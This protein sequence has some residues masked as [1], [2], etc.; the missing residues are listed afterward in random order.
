[1][2]IFFL[3]IRRPPR[4]TLFPYTTLFRSEAAL[5]D[6][7]RVVG[8]EECNVAHPAVGGTTLDRKSTRLNSSHSSIS[9]AVFCLKKKRIWRE[10]LSRKLG[11]LQI[12]VDSLRT[13]VGRQLPQ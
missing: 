4:S 5:P 11:R 9:Y 6:D 12:G 2:L 7:D 13:K 8:V 1:M 10:M 3:M